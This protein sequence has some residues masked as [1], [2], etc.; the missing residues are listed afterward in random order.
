MLLLKPPKLPKLKTLGKTHTPA[1]RIKIPRPER[2]AATPD[3]LV[4]G[5]FS[6]QLDVWIIQE[7]QKIDPRWVPQYQWGNAWWSLSTRPEAYHPTRKIVIYVDGW[8][9]HRRIFKTAYDQELRSVWPRLGY[10]LVEWEVRTLEELKK[11]FYA[12][13]ARDIGN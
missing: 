13:Y 2:N 11:N 7:L 9:Y 1:P 10:K 6:S 3:I 12:W 8:A 5:D 4:Y